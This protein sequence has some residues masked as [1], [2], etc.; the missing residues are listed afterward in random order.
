MTIQIH[1]SYPQPEKP[2]G[3]AELVTPFGCV[4]IA[5][6]VDPPG[7]HGTAVLSN[8]KL[9]DCEAPPAPAAN[10]TD[11]PTVWLVG[12]R[13]KRGLTVKVPVAV[14]PACA[15]VAVIVRVYGQERVA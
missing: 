3:A 1:G 4:T 2:K 12:P 11:K 9:P 7:L 14:D 10:V 8:I 15:P 6:T 13:P 5:T